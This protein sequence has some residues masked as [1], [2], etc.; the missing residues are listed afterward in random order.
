MNEE[1]RKARLTARFAG[2]RK[3]LV[4]INHPAEYARLER[5]G[6]LESHLMTI[7]AEAA[8]HYL[9]LE[10]QLKARAEAIADPRE[11]DAY[12]SQMGYSA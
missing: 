8:D 11:R 7:G 2:A 4:S 1:E 3:R 12:L 5:E 6:K 9:T 10:G